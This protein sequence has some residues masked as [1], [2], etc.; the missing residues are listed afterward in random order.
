[1]TNTQRLL[2]LAFCFMLCIVVDATATTHQSSDTNKLRVRSNS[3]IKQQ[4]KAKTLLLTPLVG[5]KITQKRVFQNSNNK[6]EI[7]AKKALTQQKRI[8]IVLHTENKKPPLPCHEFTTS[9]NIVGKNHH[10]LQRNEC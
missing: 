7:K 9:Q 8:S 10:P 5:S 3:E 4:N 6:A 1:M 2:G